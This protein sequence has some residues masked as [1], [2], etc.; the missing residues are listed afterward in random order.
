MPM[1][2]ANPE[3]LEW[4]SAFRAGMYGFDRVYADLLALN[5][6]GANR[7]RVAMLASECALSDEYF[8]DH[9][10][11]EARADRLEQR[12]RSGTY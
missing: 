9:E 3:A 5:P 1:R 8:D 2:A 4:A 6:E 12:V 10:K 7:W 11:W